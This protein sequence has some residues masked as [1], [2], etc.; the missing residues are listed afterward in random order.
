MNIIVVHVIFL[1]R[2]FEVSMLYHMNVGSNPLY[3][4]L[5]VLVSARHNAYAVCFKQASFSYYLNGAAMLYILVM[6]DSCNA[7]RRSSLLVNKQLNYFSKC[8]HHCGP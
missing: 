5:C 4:G 8:I 3:D 2:K 1:I 7:E 6:I